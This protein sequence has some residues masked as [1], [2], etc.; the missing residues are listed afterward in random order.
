[1]DK[2]AGGKFMNIRI[3]GAHNRE[4]QTASCICFLIDDTL[5]I[6]A[7]GLTSNLS[8]SEQKQLNSIILTHQH[9]DHIR[10]IP[11]IALNLSL[12]GASIEVYATANVCATIKAHLLN[13]E[14]YPK[15]QELP[16]PKPT[17]SF[18][19]I[20]PY[21]PQTID[22]HE[23]LAIPVNHLSTTV[24]YQVSDKQGGTIFYTADTGPGLSDC[25]KNIS[26]HLLFVDV[27][28]PN[29]YE[30]FARETGHLTPNLLGQ[31]LIAFRECKGYL[32][33]VI[34]VHMDVGLEPKIKEEIA[35]VAEELNISITVA[36]E[37]MQ[38]HV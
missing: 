13:G 9:Y 30:E 31:E 38:L 7:G 21:V 34:A 23:I 26:P 18:N 24:G 33:D 17:V 11:A 29:V 12:L 32:P 6:D 5:S 4:S 8:I 19:D 3:L 28:M 14:V 10:D 16:E 27:T 2:K 37:G 22:G 15:F 1:L 25:W 35:A 20:T 36:Q